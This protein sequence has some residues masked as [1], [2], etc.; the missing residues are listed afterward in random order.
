M[1]ESITV[2]RKRTFN[3][4]AKTVYVVS[5]SASDHTPQ[6]YSGHYRELATCE[7]EA[8]ANEV[9]RAFAEAASK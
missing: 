8:V 4:T 5:E 9:M 7:T 1:S 6:Y 2:E 3:V